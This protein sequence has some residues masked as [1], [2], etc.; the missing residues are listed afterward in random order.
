M[1]DLTQKIAWLERSEL[2]KG[3]DDSIC[4]HMASTALSRHYAQRD[5]IFVAGDL[6]RE[7]LLLTEGRAKL[8][9]LSEE[10]AEVILR[11]CV[12]GE[13]V[14]P[15]ALVPECVY[16]STAETLRACQLLA[17]DAR[18]FDAAQGRF[19]GL[20]SNA[21]SV[22]ERR[23]RELERRHCE[24]CTRKVSPRLALA[25]LHLLEQIGHPV[26]GHVEI[27]LTRESLARM[28]ATTPATVSRVLNT[29]EKI[30]ILTLRREAIEVCNI[31]GL[32]ALC[33]SE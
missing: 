28:T 7:V 27:Q 4:T 10:G 18:T 31:P 33:E 5:V 22:L 14:Y 17:W 16:H 29:W 32:F 26:N 8:M 15:P 11:L 21:K 6:I 30:G 23:I 1:A 20:L 2:F 25:L 24:A 12:P 19:R 9:R 3:L 13:I